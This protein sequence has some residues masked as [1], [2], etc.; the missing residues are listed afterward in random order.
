MRVSEEIRYSVIEGEGGRN[1]GCESEE[2][3]YSVIEGEGRRNR[4]CESEEIKYSVIRMQES[5][6]T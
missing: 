6:H 5:A 4:V 3:K 1:K 2:M